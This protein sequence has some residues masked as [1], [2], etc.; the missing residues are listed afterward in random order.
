MKE[1]SETAQCC[2]KKIM[3]I[4]CLVKYTPDVEN[5]IY[6][7]EKNVLVREN[8]RMVLNPDDASALAFAL[9]IKEKE[10]Q[11]Y[12]EAVTMAPLSVIPH[13]EDLLR[14]NVDTAVLI[15]DKM[16]VGS[17]TYVTSRILGKYLS[18]TDYD[19]ILTGTRTIDGD[20]SHVPAQV[21]EILGLCQMSGVSEIEEASFSKDSAVVETDEE[22]AYAKYEISL[23][24]VISMQS[25]RKYK[26][27]YIR[28]ADLGRPVRDRIA[29]I[30][31]RILGFSAEEVGV[32]GSLTR[33]SDTFVNPMERKR[34]LVVKND[35]VGISLVYAW[36]KEKGF[37]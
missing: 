26:L 29:I 19:C 4:I 20:T 16:Y 3:R 10:P 2:F 33:I 36:L 12:I 34:K 17:D 9:R 1:G 18:R 32:K 21:A 31:N 22:T 28:Y 37:V 27:P 24:A 11:T 15:S 35:E 7:Y 14:L 13:L 8:V 5:F 25:E 6:D 23:P 30:D